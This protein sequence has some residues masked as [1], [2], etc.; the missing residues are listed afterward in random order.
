MKCPLCGF[1]FTEPDK[2]QCTGCGKFHTC[3]MERCPNCGYEIV[4]E[5][6]LIKYLRDAIGGKFK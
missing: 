5:T 4:Q 6:K 2:S 1:D 3:N